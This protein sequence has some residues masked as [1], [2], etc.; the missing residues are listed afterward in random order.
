MRLFDPD[1]M[2]SGWANPAWRMTCCSTTKTLREVGDARRSASSHGGV[3]EVS[4]LDTDM[5]INRILEVPARLRMKQLHTVLQ[6][7][8]GWKN[9]H[10]YEFRWGPYFISEDPDGELYADVDPDLVL[11][12]GDVTLA[13]LGL[14]EDSLLTYVYDFGDH[15]VHSIRV[16]AEL[17]GP[18]PR[19]RV[20]AEALTSVAGR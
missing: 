11:D 9:Y 5:T 10:L 2:Y 4:L 15:W 7:A 17:S 13:R 19:P 20:I 16:T 6:F 8:M 18:I 1:G 3:Q 14:S 12:P